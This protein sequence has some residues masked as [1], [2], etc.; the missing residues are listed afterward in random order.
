MLTEG[1]RITGGK[2][3]EFILMQ[4]NIFPYIRWVFQN[5]YSSFGLNN[6]FL[7]SFLFLE[8]KL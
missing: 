6:F 5:E 2:R 8:M 7:V 1:G 4:I 3:C